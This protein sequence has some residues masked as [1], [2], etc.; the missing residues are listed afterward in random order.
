MAILAFR[1]AFKIVWPCHERDKNDK[2]LSSQPTDSSDKILRSKVSGAAL[3]DDGTLVVSFWTDV[4]IAWTLL[5]LL[6]T[7]AHNIPL[8]AVIVVQSSCLNSVLKGL[9]GLLNASSLV[10]FYLW[11]GQASFYYQVSHPVI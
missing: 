4:L 6:L 7:R 10:L 3:S 1:T 8:V 5:M 2:K 11:M 9:R